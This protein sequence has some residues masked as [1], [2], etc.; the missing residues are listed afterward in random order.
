[1]AILGRDRQEVWEEA[2]ESILILQEVFSEESLDRTHGALLVVYRD[3]IEELFRAIDRNKKIIYGNFAVPGT[4]MRGFDTDEI[5]WLQLE[6][7]SVI[8]GLVGQPAVW[9]A[10]YVDTAE[11]AGM[12][13]DICSVDRIALGGY[14]EKVLPPP[15]AGFYMTTPCDS[16]TC[17]VN[18][19][20]AETDVPTIVVDMPY[21]AGSEEIAYVGRQYAEVID[22]LEESTRLKFDEGRLRA[23]C[24]KY[25]RMIGLVA[26]WVE[27]R[28]SVPAAQPC[29]TLS[30]MAAVVTV[31]SGHDNGI[32][33]ASE[34]LAELKEMVGRGDRA[35]EGEEMRAIWYGDPMWSDINFYNWLEAECKVT[36]PMDMFGFFHSKSPIDTSGKKSM[37]EGIAYN[38]M[39]NFPMT[40]QLLGSMDDYILDYRTLCRDY[41]ADFGIIP[42]HL[43]CSHG[44]GAVGMIREESERLGIPLLVFEFDMLDPR[45]TPRDDIELIFKNFVEDIV[46]PRKFGGC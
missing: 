45:I 1:M 4:L 8:Q 31:F 25:N 19:M 36:V 35:V 30:L 39:R 40:R 18:S 13:P 6:A 23:A 22:F 42:G 14:L 12:A 7:L 46:R 38:A 29:E 41:Q 24:E 9:N 3:Y 17:L 10:R 21:S 2:Y 43:G 5:F 44:W 37:L 34:T 33:Y 26:D 32:N 27:L 15:D 20:V 11:A 28:K 16:Q